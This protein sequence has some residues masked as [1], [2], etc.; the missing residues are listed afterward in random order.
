ML[1]LGAADAAA[2]SYGGGIG[3][4]GGAGYGNYLGIGDDMPNTGTEWLL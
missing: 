3:G 4:R 2:G 1:V